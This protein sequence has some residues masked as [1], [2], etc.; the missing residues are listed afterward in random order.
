MHPRPLIRLGT[1]ALLLAV[2]TAM[3]GAKTGPDHVGLQ[4]DYELHE[5]GPNVFTFKTTGPVGTWIYPVAAV[6]FNPDLLMVAFTP[7]GGVLDEPAYCAFAAQWHMFAPP[8][9]ATDC[10]GG[11]TTPGPW[12]RQQ[13]A[14]LLNA[15]L[16]A[17][18]VDV[19]AVLSEVDDEVPVVIPPMIVAGSL[20]PAYSSADPAFPSTDAVKAYYQLLRHVDG[21]VAPESVTEGWLSD[22]PPWAGGTSW[23][24]TPPFLAEYWQKVVAAPYDYDQGT[25]S[26]DQDQ[27]INTDKISTEAFIHQLVEMQGGPGAYDAIVTALNDFN[28]Q[29]SGAAFVFELCLQPIGVI[30]PAV[31]S[32]AFPLSLFAEATSSPGLPSLPPDGT[33]PLGPPIIKIG[34]PVSIPIQLRPLSLK[35]ADVN[36]RVIRPVAHAGGLLEIPAAGISA[37]GL[38]VTFHNAVR[39]WTKTCA[40]G[41]PGY[42]QTSL[43]S[44]FS[45]DDVLIIDSVSNR[46]GGVS[47][48]GQSWAAVVVE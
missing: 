43:P 41:K 44:G 24:P 20:F 2:A 17:A 38:S 4:C 29:A 11:F 27:T 16:A 34:N 23:P 39:S 10:Y 40:A 18:N 25:P 32:S 46:L 14:T 30:D 22:Y 9:Y 1:N 31:G 42:I 12:T 47:G 35:A 33:P 45:A 21:G 36:G 48:A 5:D 19:D 3:V 6:R 28:P 7:P 26:W 15:Q 8:G 13:V 37:G